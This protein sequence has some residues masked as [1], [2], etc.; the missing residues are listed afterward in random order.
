M[1]HYPSIGLHNPGAHPEETVVNIYNRNG[2]RNFFKDN[3][4]S[5][6]H[7]MPSTF[8]LTYCMPQRVQETGT[9]T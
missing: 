2:C 8:V 3:S 4:F 9:L 6:E 7:Y 1:R 5:P